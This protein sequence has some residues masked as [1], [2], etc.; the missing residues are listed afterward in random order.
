MHIFCIITYVILEINVPKDGYG[1]LTQKDDLNKKKTYQTH[2]NINISYIMYI[3]SLISEM[4]CIPQLV[5]Y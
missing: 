3:N 2:S 5:I 1:K 4:I